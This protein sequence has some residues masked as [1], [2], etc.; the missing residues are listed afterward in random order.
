MVM[1]GRPNSTLQVGGTSNFAQQVCQHKQGVVE[2]FAGKYGVKMC[3]VWIPAVRGND[4]VIFAG[5]T[6]GYPRMLEV[7]GC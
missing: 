1:A 5:M 3:L 7:K 4:D 6:L 2:G